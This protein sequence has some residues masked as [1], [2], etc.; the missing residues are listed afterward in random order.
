[1][2][3]TA[4]LVVSIVLISVIVA[5]LIGP[6]M[7]GLTSLDDKLA[8]S[9]NERVEYENSWDNQTVTFNDTSDAQW[10][11]YKHINY[12][13]TW[14]NVTLIFGYTDYKNYDYKV[15]F[16]D[17]PQQKGNTWYY[18][19]TLNKTGR[20]MYSNYTDFEGS[21]LNYTIHIEELNNESGSTTIEFNA[22]QIHR[23]DEYTYSENTVD[24]IKILPYLLVVLIFIVI[25]IVGIGTFYI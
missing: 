25:L 3:K 6:A 18:N 2:N 7:T 20:D 17:D 16:Q 5:V 14:S 11:K 12:N 24:Y 1:M 10:D 22:T 13:D 9:H 23:T 8:E 21:F 4:S 19:T 15:V